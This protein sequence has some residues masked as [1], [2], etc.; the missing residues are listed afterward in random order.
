VTGRLLIVDDDGATTQT[1]ARILRLEGYDVRTAT[2][3]EVALCE[4]DCWQPDAIILDLWM[5][6]INGLGFLYRLRGR[7][8]RRDTPV[9]MVTGDQCLEDTIIDEIHELG[10]EVYF[11]P[12][13]L[14]DLVTVVRKLVPANHPTELPHGS[15]PGHAPASGLH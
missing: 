2:T 15:Q 1:F 7:E 12:L 4:N 14:E 10:A 9:V 5:P 11:K 3:A 6:F 13:W 8:D